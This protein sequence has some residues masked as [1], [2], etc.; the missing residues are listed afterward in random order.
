M[1][2]KKVSKRH[3]TSWMSIRLFHLLISVIT[4]RIINSWCH[5]SQAQKHTPVQFQSSSTNQMFLITTVIK[6]IFRHRLWLLKE[7]PQAP[8][9]CSI[10]LNLTFSHRVKSQLTICLTM[11]YNLTFSLLISWGRYLFLKIWRT[12]MRKISRMRFGL[13]QELFQNHIGILTWVKNSTLHKWS[14]I[15]K[16][17]WRFHFNKERWKLFL[18][19]SR[20][21]KRWYF[22]LEWAHKSSVILL[23]TT[24]QLLKSYWYAWHTPTKS[25][26]TMMH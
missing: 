26:S 25:K 15:L 5:K 7:Q 8:K 23:Q 18:K 13:F 24:T 2:V 4:L 20:M 19:L 12:S 1:E 21:T 9:Q 10:L 16:R 11:N 14:T 3:R 17:H 6:L 22:T